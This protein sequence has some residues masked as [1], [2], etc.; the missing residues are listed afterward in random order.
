MKLSR[1]LMKMYVKATTVNMKTGGVN[2]GVYIVNTNGFM[3]VR[4]SLKTQ[5]GKN[6]RIEH[7]EVL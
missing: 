5:I 6:E 3:F 1:N 7:V 4:D 2:V